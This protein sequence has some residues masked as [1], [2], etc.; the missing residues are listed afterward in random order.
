MPCFRVGIG[1]LAPDPYPTSYMIAWVV[2]TFLGLG[3]TTTMVQ[4][5]T[6][7]NL[8]VLA[9]LRV[10]CPTL[11]GV[12][13]AKEMS[14]GELPT[15]GYQAK[16]RRRLSN[17]AAVATANEQLKLGH[18]SVMDTQARAIEPSGVGSASFNTKLF[19]IP[20]GVQTAGATPAAPFAPESV[21]LANV[22]SATSATS[23]GGAVAPTQ[24]AAGVC[25]AS[26]AS[27][28]GAQGSTEFASTPTDHD[29]EMTE[30]RLGAPSQVISPS[31]V[32]S[33]VPRTISEGEEE[34]GSPLQSEMR[35]EQPQPALSLPSPPVREQPAASA[36]VGYA[37]SLSR[38]S[39]PAP[40][41]SYR[42][43]PPTS[44]RGANGRCAMSLWEAPTKPS[45][46]SV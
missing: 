30:R 37:S 36:R 28:R 31:H 25:P 8:N 10:C 17:A 2:F 14:T 13:D 27:A 42:A 18:T 16:R 6:D 11:C 4:T 20:P 15:K 3:F 39:Q 34:P 1:D 7:E 40:S 29:E 24:D 19:Q 23:C 5:L 12:A 43:K 33:A 38:A 22:S 9:A 21:S 32:P 26:H 41:A 45:S 44:V 35:G 46:L